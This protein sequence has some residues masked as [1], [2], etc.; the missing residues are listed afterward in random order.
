MQA[1]AI[2]RYNDLRSTILEYHRAASSYSRL[3]ATQAAS[4]NSSGP[5][6]MEIGGAWWKGGKGKGKRNTGKVKGDN[7]KGKG[8]GMDTTKEKEKER[9]NSQ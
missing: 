8:Y 6:P 4:S 9:A 3:Q 2:T 7:N 1:G 5:T